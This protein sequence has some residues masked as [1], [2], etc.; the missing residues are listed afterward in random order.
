MSDSDNDRV[1]RIVELLKH[2]ATPKED[3]AVII[4]GDHANVIAARNLRIELNLEKSRPASSRQ[5]REWRDELH[6]LV[7][8]RAQELGITAE[9]VYSV[10]SAS[11]GRTIEQLSELKENELAQ[12]YAALFKLRRPAMEG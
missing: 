11:F 9:Q 8:D 1:G 2:H 5:R 10:A 6:G 4:S 3:A 12:L 7:W